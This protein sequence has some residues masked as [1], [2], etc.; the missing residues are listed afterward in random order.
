MIWAFGDHAK[1]TIGRR[2]WT[3]YNLGVSIPFLTETHPYHSPKYYAPSIL[4]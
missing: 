4:R 3:S 1:H 2:F